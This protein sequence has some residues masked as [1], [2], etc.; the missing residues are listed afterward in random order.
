M[1]KKIKLIKRRITY[2]RSMWMLK[3]VIKVRLMSKITLC[4]TKSY[5]WM[6]FKFECIKVEI[7]VKT[8]SSRWMRSVSCLITFIKSSTM[9]Y[10]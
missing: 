6:F 9:S 5:T 10:N 8:M 1:L 7:V 3:I 4:A 2:I